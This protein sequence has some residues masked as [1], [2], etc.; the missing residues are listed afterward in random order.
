MV[1]VV[2]TGFVG[3][4]VVW[5]WIGGRCGVG[6]LRRCRLIVHIP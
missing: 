2:E 1:S 4:G 3:A 6:V 5:V